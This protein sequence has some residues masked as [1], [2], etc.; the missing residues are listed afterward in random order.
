MIF[1]VYPTATN[2]ITEYHFQN[3]VGG[4]EELTGNIILSIIILRPD[5]FSAR[6]QKRFRFSPTLA[7]WNSQDAEHRK[8]LSSMEH[9]FN[10]WRAQEYKKTFLM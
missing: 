8:V 10:I 5:L 6:L 4:E 9:Q 2:V 3:G 1:N 7:I